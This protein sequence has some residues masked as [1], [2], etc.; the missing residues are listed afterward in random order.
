MELERRQAEMELVIE[1]LSSASAPLRELT[2]GA[3]ELVAAEGFGSET[4]CADRLS[5]VT[6]WPVESRSATMHA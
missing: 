5:D 2:H 6:A 1:E 3:N 4:T